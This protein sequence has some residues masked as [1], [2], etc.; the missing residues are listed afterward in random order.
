MCYLSAARSLPACQN[1]I[2]MIAIHSTIGCGV[3]DLFLIKLTTVFNTNIIAML[4]VC[5]V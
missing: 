1:Y 5:H 4:V 3:A 2:C